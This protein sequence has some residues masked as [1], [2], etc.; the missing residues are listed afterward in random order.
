[1][2]Q[3]AIT[4]IERIKNELLLTSDKALCK[5]LDIKPN[6][7]STWKKRDTLDFN[8]VIALCNERQLNLNYIF[9]GEERE[10]QP[11]EDVTLKSDSHQQKRLLVVESDV[12]KLKL[13]NTNRNIIVLKIEESTHPSVAKGSVVVG[14][15][16]RKNK[17]KEATAYIIKFQNNVCVIDELYSSDTNDNCYHLKYQRISDLQEIEPEKDISD[18]YQLVEALEEFPAVSG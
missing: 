14:Q 6:T 10:T 15:K 3:S 2:A 17:I 9:F 1:M 16:I 12:R 13:V 8:K 18:I 4:V 7:L 11:T 5:L